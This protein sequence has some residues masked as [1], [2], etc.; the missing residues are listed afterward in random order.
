MGSFDALALNYSTPD[1]SRG[2]YQARPTPICEDLVLPLCESWFAISFEAIE[3]A[4]SHVPVYGL[5]GKLLL[6]AYI[7]KDRNTGQ[8][9]IS[10]SMRQGGPALGTLTSAGGP[11]VIRDRVGTQYGEL[12][13]TG[14]LSYS[15]V[16]GAGEVARIV[17]DQ[18]TGEMLLRST[19]D[20]GVL[21]SA[22]K[23]TDLEAL[24]NNDV[25]LQ[26]KVSMGMDPA[27]ALLC[28]V[29]SMTFN[30]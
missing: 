18:G 11:M 8:G 22:C 28:I 20:T 21:A 1:V 2:V 17:Y 25:A 7:Q 3:Q 13:H 4:N 30:A 14:F 9:M 29:G 10:I 16:S 12:M 19:A 24:P 5:S 6:A 27:L 15:L 26:V 23:C